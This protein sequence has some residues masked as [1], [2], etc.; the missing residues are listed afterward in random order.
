MRTMTTIIEERKQVPT[1]DCVELKNISM[2]GTPVVDPAVLS[3]SPMQKHIE[4]R[5]MKPVKAPMYTDMT[6]A[7]GASFD[8]FLISSVIWAGA[9]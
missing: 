7:F 8:A 1:T 9:S 3:I 4:M 2:R 5:K 6:I